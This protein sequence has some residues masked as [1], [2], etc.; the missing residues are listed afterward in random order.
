LKVINPAFYALGDARTPM[1][2]SLGSILVNFGASTL[3][4]RYAGMGHQGLALSTSA[5]AL[6]GFVFQ[7]TLLRIRISGV[8]GRWLAAQ[9]AR[10]GAASLAMAGAIAVS[11]HF[12]EAWLGVS[13]LARLADVLVSIPVGA[14]VYYAG[15]RW[16]GV[17]E[18]DMAVRAF[19]AP[20]RRRFERA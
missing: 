8:H 7:F 4:I 9:V 14:A 10:I 20:V 5:V 11:S 13:Q 12:M 16:L 15:C 18:I 1:W 3:L 2:I 6:S 17:T 19:A